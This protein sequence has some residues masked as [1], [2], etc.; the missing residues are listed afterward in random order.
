MSQLPLIQLKVICRTHRLRGSWCGWG[1]KIWEGEKKKRERERVG[2]LIQGKKYLRKQWGKIVP[3][4]FE[5]E[6]TKS[7]FTVSRVHLIE[8]ESSELVTAAATQCAREKWE[9]IHK[10]NK[11]Q[12][13]FKRED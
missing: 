3:A 10:S 11:K 12:Q 2:A 7:I 8:T 1:V 9:V 6:I 13:S 5:A 4:R